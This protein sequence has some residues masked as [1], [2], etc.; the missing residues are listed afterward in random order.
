LAFLAGE[1]SGDVAKR[2]R[3]DD[4]AAAANQK[5]AETETEPEPEWKEHRCDVCDKTVRGETERVAHFEGRRHWRRVSATRKKARGGHGTQ[6]PVTN[7]SAGD[8]SG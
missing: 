4:A 1:S 2:N 8:A 5:K 6:A 3:N 7:A